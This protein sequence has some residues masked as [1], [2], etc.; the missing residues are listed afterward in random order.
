MPD[1]NYEHIELYLNDGLSPV[2][3]QDFE[4]RLKQDNALQEQLR[5]YKEVNGILSRRMNLQEDEQRF[6]DQLQDKKYQYFSSGAKVV[7]MTSRRQRWYAVAS[8]AV[9][10]LLLITWWA[11]WQQNMLNR[12]GQIEMT[13]STVRGNEQNTGLTQAAQL[14]NKK[15][16]KQALPILDSIVRTNPSDVRSRFYRGITL[17]HL[18]QE[19]KAREDLNTIYRGQSIFQY[20]AAYFIALS[21]LEDNKDSS[22]IW[23]QKIPQDAAVYPKAEKILRKVRK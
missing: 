12:F 16:Y 15:K 4:Q 17:L 3:K 19:A 13:A 21:Y 7:P 8:V 11:P 10:A 20:N 18:Q 6:R 9:I 5:I 2:E 14:F 22:R 23:L 1:T